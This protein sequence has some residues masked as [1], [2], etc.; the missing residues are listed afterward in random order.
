M[1][2]RKYFMHLVDR[3]RLQSTLRTGPNR[4]DSG[5]PAKDRFNLKFSARKLHPLPHA[6][7]PQPLLR[8]FYIKTLPIIPNQES[9]GGIGFGERQGHQIPFSMFGKIIQGLLQNPIDD[10]PYG[11]R[12]IPLGDL[13]LLLNLYVRI[14]LLVFSGQPID[15][16]DQTQFIRR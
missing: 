14:R 1:I 4:P 13:N 2:T 9:K 8:L 7:Q 3:L 16:R 11:I 10:N 6:F 12:N 15:G 5:P